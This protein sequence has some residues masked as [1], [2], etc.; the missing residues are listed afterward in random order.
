METE[1][2]RF[3]TSEAGVLLELVGK[4]FGDLKAATVQVVGCS[5]GA[6]PF[7]KAFFNQGCH[8]FLINESLAEREKCFTLYEG[9]N[10]LLLDQSELRNET[11]VLLIF[12]KEADWLNRAAISRRMHNRNNAP[13]FVFDWTKQFCGAPQL[14]KLYN[15]FCYNRDDL[16]YIIEQ[17]RQERQSHRSE[18]I[19]W[20]DQEVERF[21]QWLESDRRYQF[22]GI[23]GSTAEMQRIFELISRIAQ[24]DITVL[25]Q[26]ESGTGKELVARAIHQLSARAKRPFV[27]VNCAAIP[28][29]LL[30]S[31]L[32]GHVKG[33]F[34]GAIANKKGLFTEAEHGTI[35]LDEI[36][37]LSPALQ[38]KLLRF[39]QEGEIKPV[40]S[41]ETLRADVRVLA[42]T[43][44][45]LEQMVDEGIFRSD[46][47]YR[48]NVIPIV[49][50]P[51]RERA[52]DIPILAQH[53]LKHFSRKLSKN[54]ADI[55]KEAM[56]VLRCYHWPGNVRELE[57]AIEHA[58][59]L[60]ISPKITLFDLPMT[61]QSAANGDET[62]F[63][64]KIPTL[65]EMERSHILRALDLCNWNYEAASKQLGIGRTTLWR[66][67]R[68][69]HLDE[70]DA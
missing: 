17:N 10:F 64:Q 60:T 32:F 42:A 22:A 70:T 54:V 8:E 66:K 59:A 9:C 35:F 24:T 1:Y 55:T 58:V 23:I 53:F 18:I 37:E 68:E 11:D 49:I 63:G 51:L 15:V 38:V 45:N 36:A 20:I 26:G 14:R 28:E 30:E 27:V 19:A 52:S 12:S 61:I 33:A 2:F 34:T 43:N 6:T 21:N 29:N 50:P 41:N 40:G 31:E 7:V 4:I 47:F 62:P 44:K 16:N 56:Q 25:I 39:L 65:K 46:L 13:F 5:P 3:P 48:L 67:L 57:N 69:Y